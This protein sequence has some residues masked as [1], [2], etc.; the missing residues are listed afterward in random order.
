MNARTSPGHGDVRAVPARRWSLRPR[1]RRAAGGDTRFHFTNINSANFAHDTA[2]PAKPGW[3]PGRD[4]GRRSPGKH[5]SASVGE[6]ET[7]A[8]RSSRCVKHCAAPGASWSEQARAAG[9]ATRSRSSCPLISVH[10]GWDGSYN[11]SFTGGDACTGAG[12]DHRL[13]SL[14]PAGTTQCLGRRITGAADRDRPGMSRTIP[15]TERGDS[16]SLG[17][18]SY[19][20]QVKYSPKYQSVAIAGHE[21]REACWIRFQSSAP[22]AASAGDLGG[23]RPAAT[24]YCLIARSTAFRLILRCDRLD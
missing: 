16:R 11:P 10:G 21:R 24:R 8:A 22:A 15:S 1:Q 13:R 18:R 19:I 7:T 3:V 2:S 6:P 23:C 20:N 17:N 5:R 14:N 9:R 12:P 4:D